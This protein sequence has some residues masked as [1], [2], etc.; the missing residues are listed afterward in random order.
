M[1]GPPRL[2]AQPNE[3]A[4]FR[5]RCQEVGPEITPPPPVCLATRERLRVPSLHESHLPDQLPEVR[6]HFLHL[7]AY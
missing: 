4:P 2:G 3:T 5:D 7:P 6:G 1:A